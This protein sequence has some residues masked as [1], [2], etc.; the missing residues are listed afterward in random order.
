MSD[1]ISIRVRDFTRTPGARYRTDGDYSGEEYRETILQ[2]AY[3]EAVAKDVGLLVDLDGTEGY[4]TSFLEE[5]FGGLARVYGS[6]AVAERV[7]VKATDEPFLAT[8]VA[9]YIADAE[10]Q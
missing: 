1:T 10:N 5:A 7:R 8:E 3:D 9:H 2:P 4:A 6:K